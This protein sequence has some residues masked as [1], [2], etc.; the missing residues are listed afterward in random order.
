MSFCFSS[1]TIAAAAAVNVRTDDSPFMFFISAPFQGSICVRKY[2]RTPILI[3]AGVT[4]SQMKFKSIRLRTSYGCLRLRYRPRS[5]RLPKTTYYLRFRPCISDTYEVVRTQ[6][7]FNIYSIYTYTIYI[8]NIYIRTA[9]ILPVYRS[10]KCILNVSPH[11][12]LYIF[13]YVE[14][15]IHIILVYV[16]IY[17]FFFDAP[18]VHMWLRIYAW[19]YMGQG[20]YWPLRII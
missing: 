18:C 3:R 11:F 20:L 13:F 16:I 9:C 2:C 5:L 1:K 8:F 6:I 17:M 19:D 14:V 12:S 10:I 15:F 4:N 7:L